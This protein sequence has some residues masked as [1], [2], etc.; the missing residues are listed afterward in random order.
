MEVPTDRLPRFIE[1]PRK[2]GK[3]G[4]VFIVL[5]NII[6]FCMPQVFRGVIDVKGSAAYTI[7]FSRDAE[8]EIDTGIAASLIEKLESSLKRRQRAEAVRFVYDEAIPDYLLQ[9]LIKHFN[10]QKYDSL[11]G[12]GRYH[13]SKD[14]MSFPNVGPKYLEYKPLPPIPLAYLDTEG[15]ILE[16]IRQKD[17][18]LYFPYHPFDYI[19]D[20]LKT[21]ALDPAVTEIRICLYR[22]ARDSRVCDALINAIHNGHTNSITLW[23]NK[24]ITSFLA[25][26]NHH[27]G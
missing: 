20:L 17:V 27:F 1:I 13:N 26:L 25:F 21:A 4:K 15:S 22:V 7:K 16:K 11:I 5:E 18:L 8:L 2:K 6:R 24:A 9:F 10:M 3:K 12:G 23:T 14:F 19:T